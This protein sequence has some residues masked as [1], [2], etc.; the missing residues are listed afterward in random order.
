MHEIIAAYGLEQVAVDADGGCLGCVVGRV[1]QDHG[2]QHGQGPVRFPQG[3]DPVDSWQVVGYE[4]Q[5]DEGFP[6]IDELVEQFDGRRETYED[7]RCAAEFASNV[8][9]GDV[10]VVEF[11]RPVVR[12]C[13][14]Y[15]REASHPKASRMLPTISGMEHPI[16][17]YH[18]FSRQIFPFNRCI[19]SRCGTDGRRIP[20]VRV[21]DRWRGLGPAHLDA[22][23]G[24]R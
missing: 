21:D 13:N 3:L 20:P 5:I 22:L 6:G 18:H 16:A 23:N 2:A 10:D 24:T 12:Q 7:G 15:H 1:S 8:V 14:L 11:K 4:S 17:A 9:Y 19:I